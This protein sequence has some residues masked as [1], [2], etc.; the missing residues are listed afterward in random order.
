MGP[1]RLNHLR[2]KNPPKIL[3]NTSDPEQ[4]QEQEPEPEPEQKQEQEPE[5][6]PEQEQAT[7][8]S[9]SSTNPEEKQEPQE[10]TTSSEPSGPSQAELNAISTAK[11][12]ASNALSSVNAFKNEASTAKENAEKAL[13]EANIAK[14]NS[15]GNE[16]DIPLQ[17]AET[18]YQSV[19]THYE[20]TMTEAQKAITENTN[21]QNA[22]TII[23]AQTALQK[24][25]NAATKVDEHA[26]FTKT[27][28]DIVILSSETAK[29]I[30]SEAIVKVAFN[31]QIYKAV[32][33]DMINEQLQIQA[34]LGNYTTL[35]SSYADNMDIYLEFE[36]TD[37]D[38]NQII[39]SVIID[40][41]EEQQT[42]L[43]KLDKRSVDKSVTDTAVDTADAADTVDADDTVDAADVVDVA[44][45]ASVETTY[46]NNE[47]EIVK[48]YDDNNNNIVLLVQKA[49]ET[50]NDKFQILLDIQSFDSENLV[51]HHRN[52]VEEI[53]EFQN[54]LLIFVRYVSN[55]KGNGRDINFIIG[56]R[57]YI[58]SLHYLQVS[59][60]EYAHEQ[61]GLNLSKTIPPNPRIQLYPETISSKEKFV[62]A[63]DYVKTVLKQ[64]SELI[65]N[66]S[67]EKSSDGMSQKQLELNPI[68]METGKIIIQFV[69]D[70]CIYLQTEFENILKQLAKINIKNGMGL[71]TNVDSVTSQNND[72]N[73]NDDA[74]DHDD[75]SSSEDIEKGQATQGD[76]T[77]AKQ[78]QIQDN[79][80]FVPY[81]GASLFNPA[82]FFLTLGLPPTSFKNMIK[83]MI[84][85][86][87]LIGWFI[88]GVSM[89]SWG[90]MKEP[91]IFWITFIFGGYGYLIAKNKITLL[92]IILILLLARFLL[93][94]NDVSR[95]VAK[96]LFIVG[97][98]GGIVYIWSNM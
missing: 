74:H 8:S 54:A 36:E 52:T 94:Y 56:I 13:N 93:G 97:I 62:Y 41:I 61:Y 66:L 60:A 95:I 44:N 72:S 75:D 29:N 12:N 63:M 86:N 34:K 25:I 45:A 21:T 37:I 96:V 11:T 50:Q 88:I 7:T 92:T 85:L 78:A 90:M 47:D 67:K 89:F 40:I 30:L 58:Q 42:I 2:P 6:E 81:S 32:L 38:V 10:T 82:R 31:N 39:V 64:T 15:N 59:I 14:D 22:T 35:P 19:K 28:A 3:N 77:E 87:Y 76:L 16:A 33:D 4:K 98:I 5:P 65:E 69:K 70:N 84:V 48:A 79:D 51:K 17:N 57:T 71:V 20:N 9:Q 55:F 24:V 53:N 73:D 43:S 27:F 83:F 49:S 46:Q 80:T 1:A 91:T 23:D 26:K 18:A 68:L